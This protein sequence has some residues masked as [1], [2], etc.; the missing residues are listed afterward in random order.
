MACF[1]ALPTAGPALGFCVVPMMSVY[2]P[3]NAHVSRHG[4]TNP[5]HSWTGRANETV[6]AHPAKITP[7]RRQ[8]GIRVSRDVDFQGR[9]F[10][11]LRRCLGMFESAGRAEGEDRLTPGLWRVFGRSGDGCRRKSLRPV[12]LELT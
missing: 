11:S 12:R 10:L 4:G 7:G 8:Y 3:V 6:Q 1:S 9:S 2:L 5:C